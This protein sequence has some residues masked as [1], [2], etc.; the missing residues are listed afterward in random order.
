VIFG[1]QIN[2]LAT[3]CWAREN[4]FWVEMEQKRKKV[5]AS[6]YSESTSAE[7][8]SKKYLGFF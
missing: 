2:H 8:N 1:L 3:L 6:N 4:W 7:R 5:S